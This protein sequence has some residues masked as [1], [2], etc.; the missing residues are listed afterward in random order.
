MVGL[1]PWVAVP[2]ASS[3][4]TAPADGVVVVTCADV[5][6]TPVQELHLAPMHP[7]IYYDAIQYGLPLLGL[8]LLVGGGALAVITAIRRQGLA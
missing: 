4:F 3:T 7:R 6:A 1:G 5:D 8:L 2:E